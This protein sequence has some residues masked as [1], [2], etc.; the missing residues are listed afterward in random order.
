MKNIIDE[1][2][3]WTRA[4]NGGIENIFYTRKQKGRDFKNLLPSKFINLTYKVIDGMCIDFMAAIENF[5]KLNKESAVLAKKQT[6]SYQTSRKPKI[7]KS[8][9]KSELKN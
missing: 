6:T 2:N 1:Q 8:P 3:D 5:K 4:N 9:E 7:S